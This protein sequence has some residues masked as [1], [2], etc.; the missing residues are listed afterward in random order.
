MSSLFRMKIELWTLLVASATSLCGEVLYREDFSGPGS[1]VSLNAFAPD[2][3]PS[4]EVW[5]ADALIFSDGSSQTGHNTGWL[6][7]EVEEDQ[8]YRVRFEL[9]VVYSFGSSTPFGV[10]WTEASPLSAGNPSA[11]TSRGFLKIYRGGRWEFFDTG[12]ESALAGGPNNILFDESREGYE[13]ELRLTTSRTG[14]WTLEAFAGGVQL[15]L[16]PFDGSS[17][18]HEFVSPPVLTGVGFYN[19]SGTSALRSFQVE[20]PGAPEVEVP[21]SRVVDVF[22]MAGQSNMSGRVDSGYSPD[23]RDELSLFYYRT[24]GPA[25]SDVLSAG[26]FTTVQPLDSGY[27]GPEVSFA[28]S[29]VEKNYRVAI[30]KVSDGGRNLEEDWNASTY[31]T[32][33][34]YW[35][36][37]VAFALKKLEAMGYVVRLQGFCWLQGESDASSASR[38]ANYEQNFS[39]LV[40][41][42]I[43]ALEGWG[44]DTSQLQI[45]SAFIRTS[46]GDYA[47][48]VRNAQKAVLESRANASWFETDDLSLQADQL[49]YDSEGIRVIGERFAE[50]FPALPTFG[51][52]IES[53]DLEGDESN[54]DADSDGNGLENLSEY[55]LGVPHGA[56]WEG[57]SVEWIDSERLSFAFPVSR[58]DVVYLPEWSTD[59]VEWFATDFR[60]ERGA[61]SVRATKS[62]NGLN[63]LFVRLSMSLR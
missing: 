59:L 31:G 17:M 8:V 55:G 46:S 35:L 42:V 13:V 33:W 44:Y 47:E 6:P 20:G 3:R 14:N 62:L 37:D 58:P 54:A 2:E 25:P 5:V 51:D 29:L 57:L 50:P 4:N 56:N 60:I 19:G 30:V 18:A 61:S 32:W 52:W 49:H 27:Y 34:K 10:S 41:A 15:D 11:A 38:S 45:V 9:D 24:D 7:L 21:S 23:P 12:S 1:P 43:G 39:D 22:L 16:A 48:T 63:S 26:E 40:E 36:S 28:R 53:N